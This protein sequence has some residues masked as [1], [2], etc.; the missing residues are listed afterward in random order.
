MDYTIKL[1]AEQLNIVGIGLGELPFKVAQPVMA[2][3][4]GQI[5][6]QLTESD[7]KAAQAKP[8]K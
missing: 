4:N 6:S 3:I 8:K 2:A 5:A 1:T 7:P